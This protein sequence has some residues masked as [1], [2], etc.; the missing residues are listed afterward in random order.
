MNNRQVPWGSLPWIAC[1]SILPSPAADAQQLLLGERVA[2]IRQFQDGA[3][4][5]EIRGVVP[6]GAN[7]FALFDSERGALVLLGM[8]GRLLGRPAFLE[9]LNVRVVEPVALAFDPQ[10]FLSIVDGRTGTATSV[11]HDDRGGWR[12]VAERNLGLLRPS[13]TCVFPGRMYVMG[14]EGDYAASALVHG[15]GRDPSERAD[16]GAPFGDPSVLGHEVYGRG[17]LLCVSAERLVIASSSLYPELRAYTEAGELRWISTLDDFRPIRIENPNPRSVR[18]GYAADSLW[19]QVVS[20]FAPGRGLVAVQIER[21]RGMG[22]SHIGL[23]T[24]LINTR[25]GGVVGSQRDIPF[26]YAVNAGRL[27]AGEPTVRDQARLLTYT[28]SRRD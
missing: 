5:G 24:R 7:G 13:G 15:F 14:V 10:G 23:E 9:T 21:R 11:S 27:I 3:R 19:D 12:K 1:L 8:D 28:V 17:H 16:F 18:Y 20:V 2:E 26:V 25:D 22:G 4:F 6:M